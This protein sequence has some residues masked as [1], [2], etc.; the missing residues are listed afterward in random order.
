MFVRE[1]HTHR[2]NQC[3]EFRG[4]PQ[5]I[6]PKIGVDFA[7]RRLRPPGRRAEAAEDGPNGGS[8][9]APG[10]NYVGIGCDY[11]SL[12][13]GPFDARIVWTTAITL[14]PSLP[15]EG[16]LS[17]S[18]IVPPTGPRGT[19]A[20]TGKGVGFHK[21]LPCMDLPRSGNAVA[22]EGKCENRGFLSCSRLLNE[23]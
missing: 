19:S 21:N 20:K 6:S 11:I 23:V 13:A 15:V 14:A 10:G 9:S 7:R 1:Q 5:A 16:W 17:G 18:L 22:W 2:A 8:A 3:R 12:R 4:S